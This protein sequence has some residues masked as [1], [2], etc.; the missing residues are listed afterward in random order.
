VGYAAN[1][2][3]IIRRLARLEKALFDGKVICSVT[4]WLLRII[5]RTS[6]WLTSSIKNI[7]SYGTI[8]LAGFA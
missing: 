3:A 5:I 7:H 6:C 8:F 1:N 2:L 4:H